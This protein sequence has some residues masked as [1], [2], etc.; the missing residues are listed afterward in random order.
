MARSNQQ[1][2]ISYGTRET[3]KS[4]KK[5]PLLGR[6]RAGSDYQLLTSVEAEAATKHSGYAVIDNSFGAIEL[7]V[8]RCH[9]SLCNH[10]QSANALGI[11]FGLH[12]GHQ[13]I[14]ENATDKGTNPFVTA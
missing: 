7:Q 6:V 9:Y 3:F 10:A 5:N 13:Q 14:I 11:L 12:Q 8:T 4:F 1:A 2:C